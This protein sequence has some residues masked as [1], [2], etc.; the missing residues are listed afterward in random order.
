[1][2]KDRSLV[3]ASDIGTWTFC[4]RAWWLAQVQKVAH[5]NPALLHRGEA[6]HQAHGRQVVRAARL[7]RIGM[8]F[9]AIGML[10]IGLLLLL[11]LFT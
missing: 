3:R 4:H 9:F 2:A 10:S 11:Y 7:Q 1:M 8:L 5:Q 6:M